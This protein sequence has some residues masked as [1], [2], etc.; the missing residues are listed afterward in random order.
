MPVDAASP[1]NH[2]FPYEMS[3][4]LCKFDR[5]LHKR[6]SVNFLI[7]TIT[8]IFIAWDGSTGIYIWPRHFH[9]HFRYLFSNTVHS[10]MCYIP[11]SKTGV[12][13]LIPPLFAQSRQSSFT[14]RKQRLI[15]IQFAPLLEGTQLS[16]KVTLVC[17]RHFFCC[18]SALVSI[19]RNDSR[20]L[21]C[22]IS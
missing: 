6:F 20:C 3:H 1:L 22:E 12:N 13:A 4:F 10:R 14:V 7:T 5:F 18:R 9:F 19:A 15:Y 8:Q 17:G 16:I 21:R 11:G 2:C